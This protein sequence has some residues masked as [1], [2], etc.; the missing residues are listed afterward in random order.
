MSW[1][2]ERLKDA[3]T[4]I[5]DSVSKFE[6]YGRLEL[7]ANRSLQRGE[8]DPSQLC[9]RIVEEAELMLNEMSR[10]QF[11][12]YTVAGGTAIAADIC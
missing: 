12:Y 10:R 7:S 4:G 8:S 1:L 2:F 5:I 9:L 6:F 11:Q 3:F